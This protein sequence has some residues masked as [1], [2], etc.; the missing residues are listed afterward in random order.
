MV[1]L[2]LPIS[3]LTSQPLSIG[4]YIVSSS[5]SIR[6]IFN[7]RGRRVQPNKVVLG[8]TLGLMVLM[9]VVSLGTPPGLAD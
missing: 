6:Y 1:S 2:H 5:L 4:A 7:V 8:I 9:T 3:R